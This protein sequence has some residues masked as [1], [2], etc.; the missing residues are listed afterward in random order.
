MVTLAGRLRLELF[1]RAPKFIIVGLTAT[2]VHFLT[3]SF[4]VEIARIPWPTFAS[5]VGSV[6]GIATS[7]FGN[8]AWVFVC[9][10]PHRT[11]LGRFITVYVFTM[12]VNTLLF[13]LQINFLRFNY[14]VAF[15]VATSLS[16]LMNF[17]LA[18]FAVFERNGFTPLP[19]PRGVGN[20]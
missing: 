9:T 11:Y 10:A 19:P 13:F 5:A 1:V 18:K 7:Y 6:A 14:V 3:L 12:G 4:L 2:L 20:D 8:Y 16:T 17:L 15:L